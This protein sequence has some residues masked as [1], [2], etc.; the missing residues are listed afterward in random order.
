MYSTSLSANN[1]IIYTCEA[2]N[3]LSGWK[4]N[5][6]SNISDIVFVQDNYIFA[7]IANKIWFIKLC[8]NW[9]KELDNTFS[10]ISSVSEGCA[11]SLGVEEGPAT[12]SICP[13]L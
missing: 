1:R 9:K 2:D 11:R 6:N 12:T 10:L 5:S 13:F 4:S 7:V 3:N 8:D